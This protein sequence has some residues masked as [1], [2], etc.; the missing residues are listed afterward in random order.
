MTTRAFCENRKIGLIALRNVCRKNRVNNYHGIETFWSYFVYK[1]KHEP[2]SIFSS[3]LLPC[4]K[5]MC[6]TCMHVR[7]C[8]SET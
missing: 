2:C 4:I 3:L 6:D 7:E 1:L 5:H 8:M